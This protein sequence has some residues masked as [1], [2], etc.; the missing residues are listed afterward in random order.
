MMPTR[1]TMCLVLM[2]LA[3]PLAAQEAEN[4][5]AQE[6]RFAAYGLLGTWTATLVGSLA[7][8]DA[9]LGTTVIPV[10]GPWVTMTRV[11]SGPAGEYVP[12]GK[13][14]LITSGVLQ[15]GLFV[16]LVYAW[17]NESTYRPFTVGWN[18]SAMTVGARLPVR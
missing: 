9:F 1:V 2:A 14:L 16:Y 6:R 17:M 11:E 8:G 4:P 5:W 10:V 7:T 18:G 3:A 13:P 12:G 15:T